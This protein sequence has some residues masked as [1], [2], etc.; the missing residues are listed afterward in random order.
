MCEQR[1]DDGR[2]MFHKR[3]GA[4]IATRLVSG[5]AAIIR[6]TTAALLTF[7]WCLVFTACAPRLAWAADGSITIL[8]SQ[9]GEAAYDA[10]RVFDAELD[11]A[12]A[13]RHI[14]WASPTVRDDALAVLDNSGYEEW[15]AGTHPAQGQHDRAQ[16]AAEFIGWLA[17]NPD[18][19]DE[20]T[21]SSYRL[22]LLALARALEADEDVEATSLAVGKETLIPQG[23]W[24][25][26]TSSEGG[27]TTAHSAPIWVAVGP[28]PVSIQEKTSV[29]SIEKQVRD[30]NDDTWKKAAAVH[31]GE[32]CSF[33]IV[34]TLP[35]DLSAYEHFAYSVCDR[36]P[37]GCRIVGSK[38]SDAQEGVAVS[39]AGKEVKPDGTHL[40]VSYEKGVLTV[41]FADLTDAYWDDRDL[42]PDK[43]VTIT[44]TAIL[45]EEASSAAA[46]NPNGATL[47]F[48]NDPLHQSLG[49][50]A[51]VR[52]SLFTHTVTLRKRDAATGHALAG[53]KFTVMRSESEATDN[54]R[55]YVQTD[56]SLGKTPHTFVT[57]KDGT[58]TIRGIGQGTYRIVEE[59][60]PAGYERQA[61]PIVLAITPA[62]DAGSLRRTELTA[63]VDA[64]SATVETVD[65]RKGTVTLG[66]TN[67]PV[68]TPP[69]NRTVER[70]AQTGVG[71]IV[72][73]LAITGVTAIVLS[74]RARRRH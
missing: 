27:K 12:G 45:G 55:V 15:L 22:L 67:E 13:S 46:G 40:S 47:S 24:I 7:A 72:P 38:A 70:L 32:P 2:D 5:W 35:A 31:A 65:A 10:Y 9:R 6:R 21:R 56:G 51:E 11:D 26:L 29:P 52:A 73:A 54:K 48:T 43:T 28:E 44:Y 74:L 16:N 8:G 66:I 57:G 71:P 59:E 18:A 1:F 58:V 36:L 41:S 61:D 53:A 63:T 30:P 33:R 49:T 39:I 64:G 62:I 37:A 14:A 50:T 34:G 25:V 20:G 19:H 60:A 69:A 42:G 23:Y 4:M 3:F 17:G 68:I